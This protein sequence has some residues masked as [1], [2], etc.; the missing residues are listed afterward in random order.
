MSKADLRKAAGIA[1]NTMTRLRRDK[2]VTLTVLYKICRTLDVGIGDIVEFLPD[3]L[4][5]TAANAIVDSNGF[6]I[7]EKAEESLQAYANCLAMR[8]LAVDNSSGIIDEIAAC[9]TDFGV[10]VRNIM[11]MLKGAVGVNDNPY[12]KTGVLVTQTMYAAV[13][14]SDEGD[15]DYSGLIVKYVGD[16]AKIIADA[17]KSSCLGTM[18]DLYKSGTFSLSQFL[19]VDGAMERYEKSYDAF[20]LNNSTLLYQAHDALAGA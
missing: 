12:A 5:E 15:T 19:Y 8:Q 11:T 6:I 18:V 17:S 14:A 3:T 16:L 1:P 20:C 9:E 2:E 4:G 10:G 13:T 7:C